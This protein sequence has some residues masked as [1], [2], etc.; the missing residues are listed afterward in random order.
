MKIAAVVL[1]SCVALAASKA[2]DLVP[3]FPNGD[4]PANINCAAVCLWNG[5]FNF[6]NFQ[7][8]RRYIHCV[9]GFQ[10]DLE[11]PGGEEFDHVTLRCQPEAIA[12]CILEGIPDSS[13]EGTS[14]ET[15]EEDT[16]EG[17]SEDTD[18]TVEE[19]QP[20]F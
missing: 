14:E 20:L 9:H 13:S 18:E 12:R 11:C 16:S 4:P 7:S 19:F 17:T 5:I 1:L 3:A 15:S 2:V 6:P 10:F 8:C